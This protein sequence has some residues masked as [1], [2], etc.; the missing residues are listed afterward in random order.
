MISFMVLDTHYR[1][2]KTFPTEEEARD[3]IKEEVGYGTDPDVF[4]LFRRQELE[5]E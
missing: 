3:Y 2:Y 1:Q 4:R 5:I